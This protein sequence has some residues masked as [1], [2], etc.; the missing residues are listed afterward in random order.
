MGRA[1]A[2]DHIA[3]HLLHCIR[4]RLVVAPINSVDLIEEIKSSVFYID[5]VSASG[6]KSEEFN[7]GIKDAIHSFLERASVQSG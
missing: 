1:Y 2:S 6:D 5:L 7:T 4:T 3:D